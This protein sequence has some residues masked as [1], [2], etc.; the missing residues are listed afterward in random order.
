MSVV[1]A[2]V[3]KHARRKPQT[4][5]KPA[6]PGA[7]RSTPAGDPTALALA[8]HPASRAVGKV[9]RGLSGGSVD[10][11]GGC[12]SVAVLPASGVPGKGA[13]AAYDEC[14]PVSAAFLSV[15]ASCVSEP[16]DADFNV[17]GHFSR[18]PGCGH[19]CVAWSRVPVL[20]A[21]RLAF[22]CRVCGRKWGETVRGDAGTV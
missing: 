20:T 13:G 10:E 8:P 3:T 15:Y 18:C 1:M 19:T 11:V 17:E 2:K 7:W 12:K 5:S 16:T 9:Y 21:S 22:R 6:T 4:R 14:V